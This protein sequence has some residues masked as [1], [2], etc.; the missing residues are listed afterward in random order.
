MKKFISLLLMSVLLIS[1][2]KNDVEENTNTGFTDPFMEENTDTG[3][4]DPFMEENTNT[5]INETV[6]EDN[7]GNVLSDEEIN[8]AV[9]E[10]LNGL[11]N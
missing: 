10:L 9:E 2:G 11:D 4:N 3:F 7:T 8:E 5:G 1:C 6:T